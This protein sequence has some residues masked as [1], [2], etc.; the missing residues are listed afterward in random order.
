MV[1]KW[2]EI[3]Q[4]QDCG[5]VAEDIGVYDPSKGLSLNTNMVKPP[6]PTSKALRRS[7]T[8]VMTLPLAVVSLTVTALCFVLT[9]GIATLYLCFRSQPEVKATSPYLSLPMILGIYLLLSGALLHLIAS[10]STSP[11]LSFCNL[12]LWINSVGLCLMFAPLLVRL[13]RIHRIFNS[14]KA[15]EGEWS[16]R[17]LF[18][19]TILLVSVMVLINAVWTATS[20]LYAKKHKDCDMTTTP[21]L[22]KVMYLC[23]SSHLHFWVL[24][25]LAYV[26]MLMLS[27]MVLAFKTRKIRQSNFKDTKVINVFLVMETYFC[28]YSLSLWGALR[29]IGNMQQSDIMYFLGNILLPM[30]CLL[31]IFGTKVWPPLKR[32]MTVSKVESNTHTYPCV[33]SR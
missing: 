15:M 32:F 19:W 28:I 18:L 33:L 4:F 16:D 6:Y 8:L 1:W 24:L 5:R 13:M 31:L 20:K 14:M 23:Y 26:A 30:T 29:I 10:I 7:V 27:V 3:S 12:I 21:P 17:V 9:T 22:C 11:A 2:P 25:V